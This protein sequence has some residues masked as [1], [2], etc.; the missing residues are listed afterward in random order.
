[1]NRQCQLRYSKTKKMFRFNRNIKID[2]IQRQIQQIIND[3]EELLKTKEDKTLHYE[4]LFS[5]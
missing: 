1:M 2:Q 3:R 4:K 5:G